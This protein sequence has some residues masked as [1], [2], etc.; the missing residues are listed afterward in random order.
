MITYKD[1]TGNAEINA[2]IEKA[3]QSLF[4]M[5]YTEHSFTHAR[6]VAATAKQ[7]L[8]EL[9]YPERD[10]ELA[11]IAGYM[12][13]IGNLVNRI[14]HAQS[15]AVMAFTI[16]RSL[17]MEPGEIATIVTAIGN[18]DESTAL[19]VNPVAAALMLS[20]KSDVRRSRVRGS[21]VNYDIH[22]RV[23]YSV[24]SSKVVID[25]ESSVIDEK[26]F[27]AL[28]YYEIF[29]ERMLLCRRA[30]EFLGNRF[31][32]YVNGKVLS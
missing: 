18:H 9:G 7:I 26:K 29:M 30:A 23:N 4:S 3:D 31:V 19:P 24:K 12:H 32:T 27:S 11:Q 28:E 14:E 5:G 16:L 20:D 10:A 15:G 25:K 21:A 8:T 13:D 22:D 17:G 2:Y 1:I 6:R